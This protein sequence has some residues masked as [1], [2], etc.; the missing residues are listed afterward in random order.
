MFEL[1]EPSFYLGFIGFI[2]S[3]FVA[4]VI[5]G[6]VTTARLGLNSW[7]RLTVSFVVGMTLWAYQ[8]FIFG[9]MQARWLSYVYIGAMVVAWVIWRARFLSFKTITHDLKSSVRDKVSW[10]LVIGG[11]FIQII[12]TFS[13]G[14]QSSRGLFFCCGMPDSFYHLALTKEIVAQFPPNEPGMFDVVVKNYHF[15]SNLVF[16]DLIRVFHIPEVFSQFTYGGVIFSV[17]FVLTALLLIESLRVGR[18]FRRWVL[19]FLLFSGDFIYLLLFV[20]G[21]GFNVRI[22]SVHDA[23]NLWFSP[24]RVM[25]FIIFFTAIYLLIEW[26]KRK[27]NKIG[28]FIALLT[29]SLVGFKIYNAVF[30]YAGLGLLSV[31]FLLKKDVR[32]FLIFVSAGL[33]GVATYLPVNGLNGGFK[34]VGLWRFQNFVA[35]P[36]TINLVKLEIARLKYSHTVIIPLIINV[37]N[38]CLYMASVF[39][40][41]LTGLFQTKKSL[42]RFSKETHLFF[43]GGFLI[44]L[45][46]GFFFVQDPGG[47]NTV[48]F[49]IT[50]FITASI[51]AGL[52]IANISMKS[53]KRKVLFYGI[54]ILFSVKVLSLTGMQISNIFTQK[55]GYLIDNYQKLGMEYL[56]KNTPADSVIYTDI[57]FSRDNLCYFMRFMSERHM[58]MCGSGI[59][60][61][62]GV[63]T[64]KRL[65]QID[66]LFL[67]TNQRQVANALKGTDIDYMF[68][69]NGF[70]PSKINTFKQFTRVYRN[71]KITILRVN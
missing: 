59:L 16:A 52:A 61:D 71:E 32:M 63:S 51:Y 11:V 62:H 60:S 6:D 14:L 4:F 43:L 36:T 39:G 15:F 10:L 58:Y 20:L 5:P 42:G 38:I 7:R 44:S 70:Y 22:T 40:A 12:M 50:V 56:K 54:A 2:A 13:M 29:G 19:F 30:L 68:F 24:P 34:F 21:R 35:E 23:T 55:D 57:R 67:A 53:W 18:L 33:L 47:A 28:F 8:G 45:I 64:A 31:Y 26:L 27:E 41:L 9:Y 3:L 66:A 69:W 48:Q 17:M 37:F 49:L 46:L 1:L 25:G 65:Q